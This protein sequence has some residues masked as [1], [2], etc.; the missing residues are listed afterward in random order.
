MDRRVSHHRPFFCSIENTPSP[1]TLSRR[2]GVKKKSFSL[3]EKVARVSAPDEGSLHASRTRNPKIGQCL[4]TTPHKQAVISVI[5]HSFDVA[6]HSLK[7]EAWI[8]FW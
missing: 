6:V 2:R 3:R 7:H 1:V 5:S 8:A 4:A